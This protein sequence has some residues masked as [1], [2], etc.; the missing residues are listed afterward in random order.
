VACELRS[1]DLRRYRDPEILLSEAGL[2]PVTWA[3]GRSRSVRFRYAANTRL[4]EA[5]MWWAFSSLKV[6]PW[7]NE[8]FRYA[9]DHRRQR[10][11]RAVRGLAAR[12]TRVLWRCWTDHTTY[13]LERHRSAASPELTSA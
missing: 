7:A 13:E 11:H 8:A 6:S 12:W 10:Y 9:R 2:A 5:C 1:Q 3:S 4:R